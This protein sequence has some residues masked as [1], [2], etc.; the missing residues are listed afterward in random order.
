[1][2][3]KEMAKMSDHFNGILTANTPCCLLSFVET[4]TPVPY[5]GVLVSSMPTLS[6]SICQIGFSLWVNAPAGVL[7]QFP[8]AYILI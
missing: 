8:L 7:H 1:M 5:L 2:V 3:M 4:C 6:V